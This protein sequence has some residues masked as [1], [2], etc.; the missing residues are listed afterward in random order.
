MSLAIG[1]ADSW[2]AVVYILAAVASTEGISVERY[3]YFSAV[4]TWAQAKAACASY[5]DATTTAGNWYLAVAISAEENQQLWDYHLTQNCPQTLGSCLCNLQ[6]GG[7]GSSTWGAGRKSWRGIE[8]VGGVW[9]TVLG[10]PLP[11]TAWG[12]GE[13]N[14]DGDC[15]ESFGDNYK[16]WNRLEKWNDAPCSSTRPYFCQRSQTYD[17]TQQPAVISASPSASNSPSTSPSPPPPCAYNKA[18]YPACDELRSIVSLKQHGAVVFK[19]TSEQHQVLLYKDDGESVLRINGGLSV[20]DL[21]M[22][23][24]PSLLATLQ[25]FQCRL[26]NLETPGSCP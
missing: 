6:C 13:P 20:Q 1:R 21:A 18:N 11:F 2:I 25:D 7:S 10:D 12:P 22:S 8:K 24:Y 16:G 5:S 3:K 19:D 9:K 15:A 23:S 4:K 17:P 26:D 14:G